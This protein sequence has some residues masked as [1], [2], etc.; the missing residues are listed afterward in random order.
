MAAV[1][2]LIRDRQILRL[3]VDDAGLVTFRSC[4]SEWKTLS[5]VSKVMT[6]FPQLR[7]F[8][9]RLTTPGLG[10]ESATP[11]VPLQLG[12]FMETC[13][14][15]GLLWVTLCVDSQNLQPLL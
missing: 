8:R 2:G 6:Q 7:H 3:L 13:S 11:R 15:S 14:E 9:T 12:H 5:K 1:Y 4:P 10:R